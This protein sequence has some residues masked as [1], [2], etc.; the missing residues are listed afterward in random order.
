ME[1]NVKSLLSVCKNLATAI[2]ENGGETYRAEECIIRLCNRFGFDDVDVMAFP[3]GVVISVKDE[4][5]NCY[6][7]TCRVK[8]RS[9][10]LRRLNSANEISRRVIDGEISLFEAEKIFCVSESGSDKNFLKWINIMAGGLSSGFFAV[11]F[12][13]KIV[14]FF[15]ALICG[16]AIQLFLL[17]FKKIDAANF[18]SNFVGSALASVIAV[19]LILLYPSLNLSLVII[20]AIMPLL[21]GLPMTNAIRD[22]INGDLISGI[23]RIGEV[24]LVAVCLA[25]GAG[26]VLSGYY[27]FGGTFSTNV[28]DFGFV[29]ESVHALAFCFL[30]TLF[31]SLLL[32]APSKSLIPSAIIAAIG[33]YVFFVFDYFGLSIMLG[34]FIGTLFI[35]MVGE[36]LARIYKMPATIFV[37]PAVIPLVPGIWLYE[38]MLYLVQGDYSSFA[39]K[40]TETVFFAGVMA[41]AIALTNFIFRAFAKKNKKTN[42]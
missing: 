25:A 7:E 11:L 34:G 24:L 28:A 32:S 37:F 41:G 17:F 19:M 20:G 18:I 2:L 3:T 26:F 9:F 27:S 6:S 38:T 29:L 16:L 42:I 1:C 35:A 22:T 23:S 12:G 40:G 13:G 30:A 5:K 21:P 14:D 39:T 4:N 15:A 31:F 33:Y 8:R 36:L 10:D